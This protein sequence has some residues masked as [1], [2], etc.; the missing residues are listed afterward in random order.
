[1][2]RPPKH[3][4]RG[5]QDGEALCFSRFPEPEGNGDVSSSLRGKR[6]ERGVNAATETARRSRA[7]A[8]AGLARPRSRDRLAAGWGRRGRGIS[9]PS[10]DDG[11][12]SSSL[13][14]AS[15]TSLL[16]FFLC[17]HFKR[18]PL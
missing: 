1:M 16:L 7:R 18:C 17:R 12:S 3:P 4:Q 11:S 9:P 13:S 2:R 6:G 10:G 5:A 15:R 8:H 14:K